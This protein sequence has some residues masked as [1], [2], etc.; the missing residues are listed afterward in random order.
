MAH[1]S[2]RDGTP[3]TMSHQPL[4]LSHDRVSV[5]NFHRQRGLCRGQ[6]R[7][8]NPVGAG[9]DV[10]EPDLVEEMDRRRVAAVLAADAE[11]EIGPRR[12]AAFDADA[13]EI[14]DALDVD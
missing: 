12:A 4:A 6:P 9:A 8:R 7:D 5:S 3:S 14:A 11:L 2:W 1:G 10:I 13:H